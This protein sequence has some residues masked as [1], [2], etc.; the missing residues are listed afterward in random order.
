MERKQRPGPKSQTE[1]EE[2]TRQRLCCLA[3]RLFLQPLGGAVS[4]SFLRGGEWSW[5]PREFGMMSQLSWG[6]SQLASCSPAQH[7]G[8]AQQLP[9]QT[10]LGEKDKAVTS[11]VTKPCGDL[12]KKSPKAGGDFEGWATLAEPVR[13]GG[14]TSPLWAPGSPSGQQESWSS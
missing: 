6:S 12:M 9:P 14:G 4:S 10:V 13:L 3:A 1:L 7:R 8:P 5:R 11:A 2:G